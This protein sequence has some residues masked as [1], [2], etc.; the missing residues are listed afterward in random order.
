MFYED[1]T[2]S[3]YGWHPEMGYESKSPLMKIGEKYDYP[4]RTFTIGKKL[5]ARVKRYRTAWGEMGVQ[6]L[7]QIRV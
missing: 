7:N 2:N 6:C 1:S 5:Q 4:H 3:S